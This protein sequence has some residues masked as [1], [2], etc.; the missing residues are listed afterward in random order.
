MGFLCVRR[1][2]RKKELIFLSII[3]LL[4]LIL[5]TNNSI[6]KLEREHEVDSYSSF[7]IIH[8]K[9]IKNETDLRVLLNTPKNYGYANRMYSVISALLIAILSNRALLINWKY[10]DNYIEPPLYKVF[11]KFNE[12]NDELNFNYKLKNIDKF[13][14]KEAWKLNKTIEINNKDVLKLSKTHVKFLEIT[15]YFFELCSYPQFYGKLLEYNLASNN[16]ISKAQKELENKTTIYQ[17]KSQDI[18]FQVGF[19]VGGNLMRYFWKP[20]EFLQNLIE[21]YFQ[22]FFEG[23]FVIG[24]QLRSY[25]LFESDVQTFINCAEKIESIFNKTYQIKWFISSDSEKFISKL[26]KLHKDKIISTNGTIKNIQGDL[27]DGYIRTI[28]DSELL[29]LCDRIIMT[30][31]STFGFLASMKSL[32]LPYYINGRSSIKQCKLIRLSKPTINH[33][34]FAVF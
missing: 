13:T 25:Y 8:E 23:N 19:E 11:D 22:T 7:K 5:Q 30:G 17:G 34:G 10:I 28:L 31:G 29:S 9:I 32:R 16:T 4:I 1:Y 24:L 20:K 14:F 12:N 6:H 18:V 15:A 2:K 26:R 3:I 33:L 21:Y 27:L